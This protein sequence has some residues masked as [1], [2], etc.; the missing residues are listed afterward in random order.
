MLAYL[1]LA[2]G[3]YNG[4]KQKGFWAEGADRN[5][6]EMIAL[7]HTEVTEAFE[8]HIG[9]YYQGVVPTT[10]TNAPMIIEELADTAIRIL[11]YLGGFSHAAL[12]P[13]NY[14][15]LWERD[16]IVLPSMLEM[17][18][19]MAY[20]LMYINMYLSH[21]VEDLRKDIDPTDNLVFALHMC[22]VVA[23][24]ECFN[25]LEVVNEKLA[26]NATRAPMHGKVF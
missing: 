26:Y 18:E 7:M 19:T 12:Q 14:C 20:K 25:L 13:E 24:T 4:N 3:I 17:G 2:V 22:N 23:G 15:E 9:V 1:S 6:A 16:D 11:D 21:A 5:Q 8:A 10:R